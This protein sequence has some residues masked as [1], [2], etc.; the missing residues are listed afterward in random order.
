MIFLEFDWLE[1]LLLPKKQGACGDYRTI[2]LMSHVL[3]LFHKIIHRRIYKVCEESVTD[4]QFG[5]IKGVGTRDDD[6]N[7]NIFPQASL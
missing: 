5:L 1:F 7:C 3:K 2:S 4:T 6:V